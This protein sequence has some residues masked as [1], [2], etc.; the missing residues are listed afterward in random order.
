MNT[1]LQQ[2]KPF[3][4]DISLTSTFRIRDKL[5]DIQSAVEALRDSL[6]PFLRQE[7]ISEMGVDGIYY[8]FGHVSQSI[9][10]V[11]QSL[12]QVTLIENQ[13]SH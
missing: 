3:N 12:S 9:G 1:N 11:E 6:L 8:L 7:N 10:E 2:T 5:N 13:N 4:Q